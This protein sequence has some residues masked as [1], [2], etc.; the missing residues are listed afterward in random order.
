MGL[1]GDF[2]AKNDVEAIR[3]LSEIATRIKSMQESLDAIE[4]DAAEIAASLERFAAVPV[5][6]VSTLP[7]AAE[8]EPDDHYGRSKARRLRIEVDWN[9]LGTSGGREVIS[10]RMASDTLVK[11]LQRLHSILGPEAVEKLASFRIS[12]G[13]LVSKDPNRDFRNHT[14][15]TVYSHQ[16]IAGTAF[17]VLTHSQT[18]QKVSDI[19][20]ACRFLGLPAGAI[21]VTDVEKRIRAGI[22]AML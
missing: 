14:N 4:H 16:R 10:E 8:P 15:G 12:R 9:A 19:R 3:R 6:S 20:Q 17:Y 11:F 18:S 1:I 5:A 7:A 21:T 13:P 22:L 2:A